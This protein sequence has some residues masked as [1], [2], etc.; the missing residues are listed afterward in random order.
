MHSKMLHPT[1]R[2][3]SKNKRLKNKNKIKT[4]HPYKYIWFL[5]TICI[6]IQWRTHN[7]L[8]S[9]KHARLCARLFRHIEMLSMKYRKP[10]FMRIQCPLDIKQNHIGKRISFFF[11]FSSSSFLSFAKWK[12]NFVLL[13]VPPD[14]VERAQFNLATLDGNMLVWD[15]GPKLC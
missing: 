3:V 6:I 15:F 7:Y 8:P 14:E 11:L 10:L 2:N 13:L 4:K 1:W 9:R 5:W 12:E